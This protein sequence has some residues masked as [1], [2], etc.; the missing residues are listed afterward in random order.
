MNSRFS[1]I[2]P[3]LLA[4]LIGSSGLRGL[5]AEAETANDLPA[6]KRRALAVM[7]DIVP[8]PAAM[9]TIAQV[10]VENDRALWGYIFGDK[11]VGAL[12]AV[13]MQKLKPNQP[14]EDADLCLLLWKDGWQFEQR[15]GKV[16]ANENDDGNALDW[17]L[18][19]RRVTDTFYIISGLD[20]NASGRRLSWFCNPEKH[21][22]V[23]TGWRTGYLPSISGDTITF[24][25]WEK[26]GY[27][28]LVWEI[29]RFDGTVGP[30]L[31]RI[32]GEDANH[33]DLGRFIAVPTPDQRGWETWRIWDR[34]QEY[35]FQR[36][37]YG[38]ARIKGDNIAGTP[39]GEATAEF[40]RTGGNY[41]TSLFLEWRLTGLSTEALEGKWDQDA[42]RNFPKPEW[43]KITGDAEAVERFSWPPLTKETKG[44]QAP[45]SIPPHDQ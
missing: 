14:R 28:P 40:S 21:R 19:E 42:R 34:S 35:H 41:T 16:S 8:S 5:G 18:K 17:A 26:P 15:A 32:T 10:S 6:L 43:V 31:A 33:R 22:L 9:K 2:L 7:R 11:E 29:H 3:S 1:S 27:S 12:V 30:L 25:G 4:V 13:Q 23:P 39:E 38:L 20:L 36:T 37:I 45:T 44:S 24:F